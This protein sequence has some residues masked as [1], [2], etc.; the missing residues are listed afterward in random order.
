MF[1]NVLAQRVTGPPV[2]PDLYWKST[3]ASPNVAFFRS[4]FPLI[5]SRRGTFEAGHSVQPLADEGRA[6]T[7]ATRSASAIQMARIHAV[8]ASFALVVLL[9]RPIRQ[10]REGRRSPPRRA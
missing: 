1:G 7:S 10:P 5:R 3:F 6:T 4:A 2:L 8:L 9:R